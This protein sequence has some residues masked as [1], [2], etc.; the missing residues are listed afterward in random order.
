MKN[1]LILGALIIV[2]MGLIL[3]LSKPKEMSAPD[4]T[5]IPVEADGVLIDQ[6]ETNGVLIDQTQSDGSLLDQTEATNEN[7]IPLEN[8]GSS[9]DR[10][11]VESSTTLEATG[12]TPLP[13][14]N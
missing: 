11:E 2:V 1:I 9:L 8:E 7:S 5:A 12:A 10:S 3:V 13:P 14:A 4:T 6:N